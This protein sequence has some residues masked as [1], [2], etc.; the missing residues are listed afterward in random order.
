MDVD[1]NVIVRCE[2]CDVASSNAGQNKKEKSDIKNLGCA[3][4]VPV[5]NIRR[6]IS[7]SSE[8]SIALTSNKRKWK[9]IPYR[10]VAH[11][12]NLPDRTVLLEVIDPEA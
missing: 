7:T 1:N 8:F 5:D 9:S 6:F 12:T 10:Y 11:Q 4:G 2:V 3:E